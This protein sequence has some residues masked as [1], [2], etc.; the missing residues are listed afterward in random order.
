MIG[1]RRREAM[2]LNDLGLLWCDIG[3]YAK[4]RECCEQAL[5][6][7]AEIG[8]PRNA[9]FTSLNLG[10]LLLDE[11]PT[12]S[13]ELYERALSHALASGDREGE[14]HARSYLAHLAERQGELEQA[15]RGFRAA[16]AIRE[17]L[18]PPAAAMEMGRGRLRL[19]SGAARPCARYFSVANTFSITAAIGGAL[20]VR[21]ATCCS[22]SRRAMTRLASAFGMR[23]V[24]LTPW[25]D[26]TSP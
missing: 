24:T 26:T 16:L 17:Q 5:A 20:I 9:S 14:A 21:S 23:S 13:G 4:A 18:A 11:A 22:A 3:G 1:E 10:W 6:I 8:D 2:D 15:E 19:R 7:Q 12:R 25:L